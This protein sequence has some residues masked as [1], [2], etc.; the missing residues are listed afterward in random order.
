MTAKSRAIR[1][2]VSWESYHT[3]YTAS[4][5][6]PPPTAAPDHRPFAA[7]S[8]IVSRSN[9]LSKDTS[10]ASCVGQISRDPVECILGEL[11]HSIHRIARDSTTNKQPANRSLSVRAIYNRRQDSSICISGFL[12]LYESSDHHQFFCWLLCR[13]STPISCCG[14]GPTPWQTLRRSSTTSCDM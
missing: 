10:V 1:G 8:P 2:N 3:V 5:E 4:R 11:V 7:S 13:L 9:E 14:M 6:I 12:T